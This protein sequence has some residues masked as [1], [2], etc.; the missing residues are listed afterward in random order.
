MSK[1]LRIAEGRTAEV[2]AWGDN[3]VLKLFRSWCPRAWAEQEA[4][5]TR[6]VQHT[7]VPAPAVGGLVEVDGNV[8]CHGDFHPDNILMSPRGAVIIDWPDA[9][10]GHPLADVARTSLLARLAELPPGIPGRRALQYGRALFHQIYLRGYLKRQRA[11]RRELDAWLP[12]G[13]GGPRQRGYS[14]R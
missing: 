6:V 13:C 7:G 1:G 4:H 9:S 12:A 14:C 8:L 2:F 11:R 3:Q 5:I 10:Q